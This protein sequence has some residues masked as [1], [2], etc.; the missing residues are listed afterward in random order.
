MP[1]GNTVNVLCD[2]RA[3]RVSS[4]LQHASRDEQEEQ[5]DATHRHDHGH[6]HTLPVEGRRVFFLTGY[7]GMTYVLFLILS[8]P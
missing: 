5:E 7:H 6:P 1:P 8:T 3:E 4:D 2:R